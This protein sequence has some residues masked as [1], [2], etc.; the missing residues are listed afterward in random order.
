MRRDAECRSDLSR[1]TTRRSA[2]H[3]SSPNANRL[4]VLSTQADV[5]VDFVDEF[6]NVRIL[7][8]LHGIALQKLDDGRMPGICG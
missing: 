1:S 8:M 6:V 4:A 2:T 5:H 7:C 3:I